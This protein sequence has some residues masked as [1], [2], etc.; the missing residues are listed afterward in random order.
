[1]FK[2]RIKPADVRRIDGMVKSGS[3]QMYELVNY[4][5]RVLEEHETPEGIG[6]VRPGEE[7]VTSDRDW[8]RK[9]SHWHFLEV[10]QVQEHEVARQKLRDL[11]VKQLKVM[12]EGVGVDIPKGAKKADL[13]LLAE[14]I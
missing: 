4:G 8:V 5:G 2:V 12:L 11:T 3:E 13:V 9:R 7:F 14:S 6:K 1:M 10:S